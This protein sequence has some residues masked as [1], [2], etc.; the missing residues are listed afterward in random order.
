[1]LF[2]YFARSFRTLRSS[3]AERMVG[4]VG[5]DRYPA[6]GEPSANPSRQHA[7]STLGAERHDLQSP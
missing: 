6:R 5:L 3:F 2:K 1:M 7:D 4:L